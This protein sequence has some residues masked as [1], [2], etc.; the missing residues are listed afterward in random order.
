MSASGRIRRARVAGLACLWVAGAV[1]ALAGCAS[2]PERAPLEGGSWSGR[3]G[4]S[5]AAT[6]QQPAQQASAGFELQGSAREGWLELTSPVG[7]LVARASWRSGSVELETSSGRSRHEGLRALSRAAFGDQELPLAA[8]FDWL[9]GQP[10]PGAS[11][12]VQASG[13]MQL[14]WVVDVRAL[15]EGRLTATRAAEPA[16]TLR[17]RLEQVR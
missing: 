4:W 2:P 13:F 3:L 16:V 5:I 1:G 8:L 11:H 9:R 14:G 7:T 12:E 6:A 10:W 15:G 17:V